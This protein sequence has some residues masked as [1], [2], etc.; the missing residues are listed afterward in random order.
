MQVKPIGQPN[1]FQGYKNILKTAWKKGK[2]PSV[3]KG[4]YGDTLTLHNVSLE[5]LKPHSKG[6]KTI[7]SNLALASQDKNNARGCNPLKDFLS[8]ER[9]ESYLVQFKDIKIKD[10][11]GNEYIESI[12]KTL[13]GLL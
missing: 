7:T 5:H 2:L 3:K 6:G 10:F 12:R 9:A 8:K 13:E 1:L 11:D 4:L